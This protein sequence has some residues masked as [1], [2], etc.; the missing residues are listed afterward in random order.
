M[1][2]VLHLIDAPEV[3]TIKDADVFISDEQDK[4]SI[5]TPKFSAFIAEIRNFY[6]DKRDDKKTVWDEGLEES[7]DYGLVKEL[8]LNVGLTDEALVMLLAATAN[9]C[10]LLL[11]DSEGE[12]IY[13]V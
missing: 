10:G 7:T 12:V 3:R 2:F 5:T 9:N 13:G 11:Y 6:P 4:D 1:S 8:V